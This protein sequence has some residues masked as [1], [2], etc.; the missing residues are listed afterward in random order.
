MFRP[1]VQ[2]LLRIALALGAALHCNFASATSCMPM[3]LN[4]YAYCENGRCATG[5]VVEETQSYLTCGRRKEVRDIEPWVL[6]LISVEHKTIDSIDG[7]KVIR[8]RAGKRYW[9]NPK[10]PTSRAEYDERLAKDIYWSFR[11]P[12][13]SVLTEAASLDEFARLRRLEEKIAESQRWES[14]AWQLA[15]WLTLIGV[16]AA[17]V[18]SVVRHRRLAAAGMKQG[19]AGPVGCQVVIFIVSLF[20]LSSMSSP[21][22]ALVAPIILLVIWPYQLAFL[23]YLRWRTR[24]EALTALHP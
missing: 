17:V 7:P 3:E 12:K 23:I 21:L 20:L 10:A 2:R 19:R 15:D 9:G 4:Y 14:L 11:K 13:L 5:F 16:L 18:W 24:R 8:L 22:F 1:P 6:S